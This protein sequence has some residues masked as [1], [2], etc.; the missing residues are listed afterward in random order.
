[1]TRIYLKYYLLRGKRVYL[2]IAQF[3]LFCVSALNYNSISISAG[4]RARLLLD[5][6]S[7]CFAS[8]PPAVLRLPA[9]P[10]GELSAKL[11]QLCI[12]KSDWTK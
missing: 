6:C 5:L 9:G 8:H 11:V 2:S 7:T 1:M 3:N 10:V 4:G 12:L